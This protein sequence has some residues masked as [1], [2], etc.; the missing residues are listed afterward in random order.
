LPPRRELDDDEWEIYE[1]VVRRFFATVAEAAT[2]EHLRVVTEANDCQLK[3]NGKRLVE[4]GYHAVY[5]YASTS[6]NYVPDVTEGERL[7]V[8]EVELAAKQ[9]QPPRRYGQSRLIKKMED[10]G[11]GTKC[12]TGD[13]P[14]L[15]RNPDGDFVRTDV[16][17]L[18]DDGTVVLADGE[19]DIAVNED[20][21]TTLSFDETTG[22][23]EERSQT[24]VS[25]RPLEDDEA[26][27][28]VTTQ[29][30]CFSVTDQH[31]LY[32]HTPD[33]VEIRPAADVS[34]GVELL[35][36]R[37]SPSIEF[38]SDESVLSWSEFATACDISSKLYGVDC[39]DVLADR[40]E[41]SGET[42]RDFATRLGIDR[43]A[44]SDYENGNQDVPV[45]I[46]G[47][48]DIRPAEIHGLNY[49]KTIHN[50][51]P[52]RWSP[53]LAR[54]LAN[55]LGDG[56]IH[57][58]DEEH[59]VDVRYHN[60]DRRLVDRFVS[61]IE[62]LF[63]TTPTVS[64]RPGREPHHRTRYQVTLSSAL[65]RVL[66]AILD[67]VLEDGC[68]TVPEP[69]ERAFVGALFDDEGHA[70]RDGKAFISNTDHELLEG[71]ADMLAAHGIDTTLDTHQHKLHIRGRENLERFFDSIPV[72]VDDK[73]YRGL[74]ALR[75]YPVTNH[76][77]RLLELASEGART[78]DEL[79]AELGLTRG[80]V[81]DLVRTLRD[82][83]Y[84]QKVVDGSN[85]SHE[86]LRTIRYVTDGFE[87]SIYA[88]LVGYSYT[89]TVV[90]VSERDYDGAVYD[91]TIDNDAPNF[92]LEGGV[93]VH[94]STR[95]NTIEKLYDRGYIESDPPRPTA[96]AEAVVAATE[97]FA[98]HVVSDEMTAQLEQDMAA[99]A[100]GEADLSAVTDESREMLEKVFEE[101]RESR[102]EI[103]DHLQESL[104]AD[105]RLGPC[106][107]CGEDLLVRRSRQGSYFVG[108][109]GFPDCRFTLP[110]PNT[111]EPLVL[112]E[113][114]DDHE[115]HEVKM[116]AG[117]DTFVHGCPRCKA[118]EADDSDD[119]V[120]G[121]CPECGETHDGTL[122]IKQL[123]SGSRL[124]GCTRYPDC[125][126][127]LPLPRRG[128]IE[129]TEEYCAE[130]DLPELVVH[131]GDEP[132]ELGCPICNYHEYQAEQAVDDLEDLDGL[133]AKTAEK[134]ADAG[135]ESL[136]DLDGA[137]AEQVATT[138][139]GVSADQLREWQAQ[140]PA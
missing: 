122:A 135:I 60:T 59:V 91:L 29:S 108:C 125:E 129:V 46:L 65:G 18:F 73:F 109:D 127:S 49:Q 67:A 93:V 68:P 52:L 120:I 61:D 25:E 72:A 12:L 140:L 70:S 116:L 14:V 66:V 48:L 96:L 58:N 28:E 74:D 69:L 105:R 114:C 101:L 104:K 76:K 107:E 20:G 111:G 126:Y 47:E 42:Q 64:E 132:W 133:G 39:G 33:G 88:T 19:T 7:D 97:E 41:E 26:V 40:R 16:R 81:N 3:A 123:R 8:A 136:S 79:A 37:R 78:S 121:P 44:I 11:L 75:E 118:E 54:L 23:V 83:G 36:V 71:V 113:T 38:E 62:S 102:Q 57:A 30:S 13:T 63:G 98:D 4:E 119:E 134:L 31:P 10:L 100:D 51:F 27:L 45:W 32:V 94:N 21:P 130:H 5:P 56:S 106:P 6:E 1:L 80:R 103:G 2:W 9:T 50:P 84:L 110:L 55:L 99:I 35:T 53:E 24:L 137:D 87:E 86:G 77:A 112:D 15:Q 95:H 131:S 82:D 43:A 117:R 124:V 17:D 89:T 138:V 92:A 128:D 85:R 115:M 90:D 139:Q 22:R 34:A